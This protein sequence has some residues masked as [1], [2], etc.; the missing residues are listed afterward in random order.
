MERISLLPGVWSKFTAPT[1]LNVPG[2]IWLQKEGTSVFQSPPAEL[3]QNQAETA[4]VETM[5]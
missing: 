5:V 1:R 4:V 3:F 2:Q